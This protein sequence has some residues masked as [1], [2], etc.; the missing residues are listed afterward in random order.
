MSPHL[1]GKVERSQKTDLDEFY[2]SIDIRGI[3]LPKQL[4]NWEHYYNHNRGHTSLAGKTPWEK[5]QD[6]ESSVPSIQEI[7][8]NYDPLKEPLIIQNYKYNKELRSIIKHK[9]ASS[10]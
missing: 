10:V 9:N 2:S 3:E 6:L 7:E 1:N 5:Y 8:K 4:H